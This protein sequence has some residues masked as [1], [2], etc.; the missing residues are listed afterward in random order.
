MGGWKMLGMN[1]RNV[2]F[3]LL[4]FLPEQFFTDWHI[5]FIDR[6]TFD[7]CI[8][9]T[10]QI[11]EKKEKVK[12]KQNERAMCIWTFSFFFESGI[13]KDIT[14]VSVLLWQH[15]SDPQAQNL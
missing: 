7:T 1:T 5:K 6:T 2:F 9:R 4:F 8:N 10:L 12:T 11:K 3:F 14:Y 13:V 15:K